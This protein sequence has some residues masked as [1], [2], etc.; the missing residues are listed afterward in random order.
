MLR[1]E[2]MSRPRYHA[3]VLTF[4]LSLFLECSTWAADSEFEIDSAMDKDPA[5]PKAALRPLPDAFRQL[6]M[7]ALKRP[8]SGLQRKAAEA[9][10][11]ASRLNVAGLDEAI[12]TLV[13]IVDRDGQESA[14]RVA[15]AKALVQLDARQSAASFMQ[16]LP[17]NG[18]DFAQIVE[19]ALAAW[20]HKPMRA[21]WLARLEQP[22]TTRRKLMLAIDGLGRVEE[23]QAEEA[24]KSLATTNVTPIAVRLQA[25]RA[26]S[27]IR[28]S[29]SESISASLMK[30]KTVKSMP[31]RLIAAT[32][33][34][35]HSGKPAI[36]LLA[37]LAI[38]A[39]PAVANIALARLLEI[40]TQLV[41]PFADRLIGSRDVKLRGVAATALQATP[42]VS[43]VKTIGPL[44]N[45]PDPQLRKRVRVALGKLAARDE[46]KS[47][48]I[49]QLEA[50][51]ATDQWRGIEQ[52]VILAV[53]LN[54]KLIADRL[55]TLLEHKRPEVLV[56]ASWGLR[57]LAVRETLPGMLR[58][59]TLEAK[60]WMGGSAYSS[61]SDEQLSQ[62]FQ[63]FGVMGFKTAD[64]LMR[65]F[66]PKKL[67]LGGGSR[68]AAIWALGHFYA[69]KPQADLVAAFEARLRDNASVPSEVLGV[70]KMAAVSMGRMKAESA[71]P[72]LRQ[73]L[74]LESVNGDVGYCCAWSLK[75]MTGRPIDEREPVQRTRTTWFLKPIR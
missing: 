25:A 49:E 23:P 20:D 16:Q 13:E 31:D 51:L 10:A 66:I 53:S 18:I 34:R 69:D 6:W 2:S 60:R 12:P 38:D 55:L 11:Q 40:D 21:V 32:L 45:D 37:E 62:L 67:E 43:R 22:S 57:R 75:H 35:H 54:H 24:L 4:V 28:E 42:T 8:E 36:R 44:L 30:D 73:F 19:P 64:P 7:Q 47:T 1:P 72:A 15:A 9:I 68:S 46:L 56:T 14:V 3:V 74:S 63:A 33:L 5:I 41:L 65:Q 26:L 17:D 52:S 39:E 50:M 71:L 58:W 27:K 70:R 29:G 61:A 59:A 48:V